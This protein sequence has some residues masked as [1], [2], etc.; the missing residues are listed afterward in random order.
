MIYSGLTD[1][2][3]EGVYIAKDRCIVISGG[4]NGNG[5]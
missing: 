2:E 5:E 3:G 4:S 1:I